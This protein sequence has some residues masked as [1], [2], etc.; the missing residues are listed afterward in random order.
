MAY[1]LSFSD[2]ALRSLKK[3]PNSDTKKIISALEQLAQ[4]PHSKTSVKR[5][6]NH[7]DAIFRLR[8]GDY[9]VLYDKHDQIQIIAVIDIGHRKDIYE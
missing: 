5:L 7:P 4:D 6:T 8:V 9:R 2:K 3:I 1:Q